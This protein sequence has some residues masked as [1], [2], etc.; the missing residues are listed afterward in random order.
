MKTPEQPWQVSGV[1]GKIISG[2]R[3]YDYHGIGPDGFEVAAVWFDTRTGEGFKD[4]H[5]IVRAVNC[6]QDLLKALETIFDGV[7]DEDGDP[8]GIVMLPLGVLVGLSLGLPP[9]RNAP[10]RGFHGGS[11]RTLPANAASLV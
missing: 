11:A 9:R 1:R 2:K 3:Q 5:R 10:R 4:A 6:H 8:D 7:E